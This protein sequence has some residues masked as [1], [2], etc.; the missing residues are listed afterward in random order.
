MIQD[1]QL[2][3]IQYEDTPE[4]FIKLPS[5]EL[6]PID[7]IN[8]AQARADAILKM[9]IVALN[10]KGAEDIH[11]HTIAESLWAL[12]GTLDQVKIMVDHSYQAMHPFVFGKAGA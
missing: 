6:F 2:E 8:C 5:T 11:P 9:L 7:A 1:E 12:Q 4:A 10:C 3:I